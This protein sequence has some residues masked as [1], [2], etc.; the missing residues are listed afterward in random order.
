MGLNIKSHRAEAAIRALAAKTG[1]GLTEAVERAV[2]ERLARLRQ[3]GAPATGASL[4]D[5]IRPL[6]ELVAAERRAKG[7]SRTARELMD[8]LYDESGL[9]V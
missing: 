5:R 4:L 3:S 9:P 7:D 1:E 6:Q 2:E 8:A